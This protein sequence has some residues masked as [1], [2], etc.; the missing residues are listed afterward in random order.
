MRHITEELLQYASQLQESLIKIDFGLKCFDNVSG[1][2]EIVER[3]GWM[4]DLEV[5][6]PELEKYRKKIVEKFL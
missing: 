2:M 3:M 5:G 6:V 1:T 4:R